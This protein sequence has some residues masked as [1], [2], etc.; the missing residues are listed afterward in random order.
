MI[1]G[2]DDLQDELVPDQELGYEIEQIYRDIFRQVGQ[3]RE[4]GDDLL[5]EDQLLDWCDRSQESS[6][7]CKSAQIGLEAFK[8]LLSKSEKV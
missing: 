2:F 1:R 5:E 7:Y 3:K 8:K 4:P 6:S